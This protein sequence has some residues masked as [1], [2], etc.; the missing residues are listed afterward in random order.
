MTTSSVSRRIPAIL[1]DYIKLTKP[2]INSLVLLTTFGGMWLASPGSLSLIQAFWTLLGTGMAVAGSG[3][4]NNV[5]EIK[6]DAKMDR[7]RDRPLPS[8]RVSRGMASVLGCTLIISGPLLLWGMVNGMSALLAIAAI[9][10]YVPIYT[11]LKPFT[12]LSTL[13]GTIPGALPPVIGWTAV[14]GHIEFPAILLFFIMFFWQ[15]PHFLAL[16]LFYQEDYERAGLAM[17]PVE[18][19]QAAAVRQILLYIVFLIPVSLLPVYLGYVGII[20][21]IVLLVFNVIFLAMAVPGLDN[22][23]RSNTAWSRTLFLFSI[24]YL[25]VMFVMFV[26][27]WKGI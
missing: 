4:F 7:T 27:D 23:T 8:G 17:L 12:S 24:V 3:V 13:V 1:T 15:P 19:T 22:N 10:S 5:L 6:T 20:Y 18:V 26:V 9:V 14:R 11:L 21:G 25:T 2:R 16:A